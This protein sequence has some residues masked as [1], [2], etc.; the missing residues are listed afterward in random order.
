MLE[1]WLKT[2]IIKFKPAKSQCDASRAE[3][4]I[5]FVETFRHEREKKSFT[6]AW[7]FCGGII[8]WYVNWLHLVELWNFV[9]VCT[10]ALAMLACSCRLLL[11]QVHA[12][13]L[14]SRTS[15][16]VATAPSCCSGVRNFSSMEHLQE[17]SHP[18]AKFL[19]WGKSF[20]FP[21]QRNKFGVCRAP[22][23]GCPLHSL[24]KDS[25]KSLWVL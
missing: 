16:T 14:S 3:L 22:D 24:R 25:S 10:K 19:D 20:R 23:G 8:K 15:L 4:L 2:L 12:F 11:L 18:Q 9:Y 21:A 6:E 1:Q 17:G 13:K 5:E 7:R